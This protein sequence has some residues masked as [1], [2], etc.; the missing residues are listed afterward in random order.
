MADA[1]EFAGDGGPGQ[2]DLHGMVRGHGWA[3]GPG[4]RAGAGRRMWICSPW[5]SGAKGSQRAPRSA[6]AGVAERL[7]AA[8]GASEHGALVRHH[9]SGQSAVPSLRVQGGWARSLVEAEQVRVIPACA[10]R[11][12]GRAAGLLGEGGIPACAG[13]WPKT[14]VVDRRKTVSSLGAKERGACMCSLSHT[15]ESSLPCAG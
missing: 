4:R 5:R 15:W 8:L 3:A 9:L 2:D 10:G 14:M 7:R 6:A 13:R 11:R 12:E 1:L